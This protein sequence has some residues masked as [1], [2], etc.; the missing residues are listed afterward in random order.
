M[1]FDDRDY[2]RHDAGGGRGGGGGFRMG[3]LQW[4]RGSIVSRLIIINAVIFI[5]DRIMADS[6]RGGALVIAEYAYF[7]VQKGIHELQIWRW[8]SYQF[9]HANFGHIFF[10]ML[11]L[12]FFGPMIERW[13]GSRRFLAFYL[14]CG[15]SGAFVT[16][17]LG[18][19]P[20]LIFFRA[21]TALVG[22]SGSLF[23]IL[24]ACAVLYPHQRVMLLFPP[25]PMTM[26]TMATFFLLVAALTIIVGGQNAGGEAAHLGGAAL[27]F[28]LVR[29]PRL[30]DWADNERPR[31][32]RG[33]G[34]W[35][36]KQTVARRD[37]AE[38]DRILTKVK[39]HG[40]HGL[41]RAEKRTLQRATQR[42]R[43][44]G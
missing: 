38:V 24:I 36:K 39:Q 28:F 13:W 6:D 12:F 18:T 21:D 2:N 43:E 44:A 30:L 29:R 17:L 25:I 26:R 5:W 20:G 34:R 8:F 9:I 42:Q 40:L 35:Q 31:A 37:S 27:G 19:I 11:G 3:G 4:P 23:G 7:S 32:D 14:L 15:V 33:A 10:N 16:V 1:G 41:T 22:A